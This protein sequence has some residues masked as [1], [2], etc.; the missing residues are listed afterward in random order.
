MRM[1]WMRIASS[2]IRKM[3]RRDDDDEEPGEGEC[4]V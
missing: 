3:K 2:N 4:Q 1:K